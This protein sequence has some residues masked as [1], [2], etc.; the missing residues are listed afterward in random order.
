M[1]YKDTSPV[2]PN[3]ASSFVT[4]RYLNVLMITLNV[5]ARV[6]I[7]PHQSRP[8]GGGRH[9]KTHL[10]PA[11]PR[12]PGTCPTRILIA[13]PVMNPLTA[14]AGMNSTIQPI[15]SKPTPRTIQPQMKPIAVPICGAVHLCGYSASIFVTTFPTNKDITATGY[16]GG[17]KGGLVVG[18]GEGKAETY[19]DCD[20]FGGGEQLWRI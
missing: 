5:A 2:I 11:S 1:R 8:S 20:I 13:L 3:A 17:R 15:L 10:N 18:L 19:T 6:L 16:E 7:S 12:R 9:G 14:G 4:G